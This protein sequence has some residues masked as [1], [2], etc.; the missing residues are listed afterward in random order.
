MVL[1]H[2]PQLTNV[3][4]ADQAGQAPRLDTASPHLGALHGVCCR[5]GCWADGA[6]KGAHI[7]LQQQLTSPSRHQQMQMTEAASRDHEPRRRLRPAGVSF[8]AGGAHDGTTS[9]CRHRRSD[10]NCRQASRTRR[11]TEGL[12]T[13]GG[14]EGA[15][16]LAGGGATAAMARMVAAAASML[17]LRSAPSATSLACASSASPCNTSPGPPRCSGA[18]L[19]RCL[20]GPLRASAIGVGTCA[21]SLL[22]QCGAWAS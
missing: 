11:A 12:R 18:D 19:Q 22:H 21:R 2:S 10:G 7:P 1:S 5:R 4:I 8:A 16:V 15:E 14:G 17:A 3:L 6:G 9:S 20:T 13:A